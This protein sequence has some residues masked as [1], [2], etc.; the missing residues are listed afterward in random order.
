MLL[1][2][3]KDYVMEDGEIS[4]SVGGC[5]EFFDNF[6]GFWSA[7]DDQGDDHEMSVPDLLSGCFI[8]KE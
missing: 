6:N 5:Y 1:D 2:C 4:F 8:Y 7:I 3:V